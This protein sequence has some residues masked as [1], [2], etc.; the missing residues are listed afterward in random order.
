M[1]LPDRRF[2][3]DGLAYTYADFVQWY[4][5]H[6]RQMWE[7]AAA[8]EHSHLCMPRSIDVLPAR[9]IAADGTAYTYTDFVDWYG[10]HANKLWEGAAATE[11]SQN[12]STAIDALPE[13]ELHAATTGRCSTETDFVQMQ[14]M[15]P[16]STE[17]GRNAT[18]HSPLN[19]TTDTE[20]TSSG[21]NGAHTIAQKD[22]VGEQPQD[23][24]EHFPG[25]QILPTHTSNMLL[26]PQDAHDQAL[27]PMPASSTSSPQASGHLLQ[28]IDC[29]RP[30]CGTE[31]LA[32]FWRANKQGGVEVHLMLKPENE[33]PATF[34]R[35]PV[36]EK[37]AMASWQCA[38]GFK[39]GDT[40]A[41]AVKKAAMTAFKSSS[42]MLCG[43]RFT[44]RKSKW[45]SIYTKPPF[46]TIEVRTR[47][48]FFGPYPSSQQSF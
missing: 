4:D 7:G 40:R 11:H 29:Q 35:S 25:E 17:H 39:F 24:T 36:T 30:L 44:G 42:V 46:N 6:A 33:K 13:L 26:V 20:T 45:P 21:S 48:T 12:Y 18:E 38:C 27:A 16:L 23:V 47:D 41:V 34:I 14:D 31:D 5:T 8:T 28:C 32:F 10:S 1:S 15:E 3:A 9:R 19:N 22:R 37:G 2:A 43:Q